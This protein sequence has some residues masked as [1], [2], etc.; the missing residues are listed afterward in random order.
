MKRGTPDH[1]KTKLLAQLLN[2]DIWGA[3]GLLEL[4]WHFTAK[5][6]PQ[7]DI[8]RYSDREIAA[9]L[10]WQRPTGKKG[11]TPECRL[12]AALVDAKWV[13]RCPQHRLIVH[14]WKDHA[15]QAVRKVLSRHRLSFV[16]PADIQP[17]PEPEPEPIE[18]ASSSEVGSSTGG[19][20][21]AAAPARL[22]ARSPENG[23]TAKTGWLQGVVAKAVV[24]IEHLLPPPYL[25]NEFGRKEPNPVYRSLQNSLE[26][27]EERIRRSRKPVAYVR[28]LIVGELKG[29]KGG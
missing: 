11:V 18:Q 13:D 27:A 9:A 10:H 20:A 25:E 3:V 21:T 5:Y 15:D 24:G 12:S 2:I 22:L 7:G 29:A 16:Q 19:T 23:R 14:D 1:P 6:A 8:G 17:E 26:N 28:S 4:L